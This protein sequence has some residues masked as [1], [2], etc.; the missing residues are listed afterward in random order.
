MLQTRLYLSVIEDVINGVRES[1]LDEGVDEQ[2]LQE[3][4]QIWENK[5]HSSKALDHSDGG[6][7]HG[8]NRGGVKVSF[9][10]KKQAEHADGK[11][12]PLPAGIGFFF[13]V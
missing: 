13:H 4:K 11:H 1:F 6:E 9:A 5:V 12:L 10:N 3:L 2:V 7:S 8:T